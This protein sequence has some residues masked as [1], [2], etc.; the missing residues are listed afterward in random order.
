MSDAAQS[1]AQT[2]AER[3]GEDCQ[4]LGQFLLQNCFN[5]SRQCKNPKCREGV[6]R[7]EQCFPHHGGRF[8]L[9]VQQLPPDHGLPPDG[10]YTWSRLTAADGGG[11]TG[12]VLGRSPCH[13]ECH[14]PCMVPP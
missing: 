13:A 5:L 9:R 12:P 2:V 1:V 8:P 3:Q 6:L 4:T 10:V 14:P 11:T 7:H